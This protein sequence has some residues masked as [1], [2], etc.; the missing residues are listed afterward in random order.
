MYFIKHNTEN[1]C[2]D[3]YKKGF[4]MSSGVANDEKVCSVYSAEYLEDIFEVI[5]RVDDIYREKEEI[6]LG[7]NS[8]VEE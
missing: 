6:V 1:N 4:D 3:I 8:I 5:K 2:F 7:N